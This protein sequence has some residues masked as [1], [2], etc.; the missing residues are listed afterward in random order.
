MSLA[1]NISLQAGAGAKHNTHQCLGGA[2][3]ACRL[4]LDGNVLRLKILPYL[5]GV[6]FSTVSTNKNK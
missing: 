2:C 1:H 4:Y 5:V 3:L 6:T